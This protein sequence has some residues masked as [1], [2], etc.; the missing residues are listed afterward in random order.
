ML[1][2]PEL[3]VLT[4]GRSLAYFMSLWQVFP[5]FWGTAGHGNREKKRKDTGWVLYKGMAQSPW[6]SGAG[7]CGVPVSGIC[8]LPSVTTFVG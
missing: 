5:S 4:A 3:Q 2:S 8:T 1:W 6:L 7:S